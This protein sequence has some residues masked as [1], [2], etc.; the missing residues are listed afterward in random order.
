MAKGLKGNMNG[1]DFHMPS[2]WLKAFLHLLTQ[3][4]LHV[5]NLCLSQKVFPQAFKRA[6]VTPLHK[7]GATDVMANK[8]S[9]SCLPFLSKI[10]ERHTHDHVYWFLEK[11]G[12]FSPW[13]FGFRVDRNVD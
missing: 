5:F 2:A 8:R 6:V 1:F 11:R 3:P 12:F 7:K 10:L 13:Q 4:L 9:I